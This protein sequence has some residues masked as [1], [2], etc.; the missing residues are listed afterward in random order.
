ML[1]L[2][3]PGRFR[4]A[5]FERDG[6]F[7]EIPTAE[8]MC[9]QQSVAYGK[10]IQVWL[11]RQP[12]EQLVTELSMIEVVWETL[13][14]VQGLKMSKPAK[15]PDVGA[16]GLAWCSLPNLDAESLALP[17]AA[18]N[19]GYPRGFQLPNS[20]RYGGEQQPY[21]DALVPQSTPKQLG[22]QQTFAADHGAQHK[23]IV[24]RRNFQPERQT[25]SRYN[26]DELLEQR[27]HKW[28]GIVEDY[29]H[30]R[31]LAKQYM[32]LNDKKAKPADRDEFPEDRELQK[33][34]VR[35]LFEAIL[36]F[37]DVI[38]GKGTAKNKG[39]GKNDA[40]ANDDNEHEEKANVKVEGS[41]SNEATP[42]ADDARS[43]F[44]SQSGAEPSPA[45]TV[46]TKR[47]RS[48]SNLE[49]ELLAWDL[50]VSDGIPVPSHSGVCCY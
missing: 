10:V 47:I 49:V 2:F 30:C 17:H 42:V 23:Q 37:S 20:Q 46:H 22:P 8:A 36:D 32:A 7:V 12:R 6:F 1:T 18:R 40:F 27:D 26:V 38:D 25:G 44:T 13:R 39:N 24:S 35:E 21:L 43:A 15:V 34:L 3:Y 33:E 28:S 11:Q 45:D 16:E 29:D 31:A 48:L 4:V 5:G 19:L 41:P 9:D 14:G 50:L